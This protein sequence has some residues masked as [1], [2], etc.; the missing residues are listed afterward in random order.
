MGTS[1]RKRKG[2]ERKDMDNVLEEDGWVQQD[3]Q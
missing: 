2:Y 3:Y 1:N